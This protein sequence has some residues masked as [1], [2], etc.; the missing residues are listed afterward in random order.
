M[1]DQFVRAICGSYGEGSEGFGLKATCNVCVRKNRFK[2]E[3]ESAK[4]GQEEQGKKIGFSPTQELSAVD[5]GTNAV[6]R[7]PDLDRRRL[8]PEMS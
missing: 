5:I 2:I 3:R 7:V 1:C 6:V 4:S 8:A